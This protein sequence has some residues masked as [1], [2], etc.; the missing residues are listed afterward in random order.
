MDNKNYLFLVGAP[1]CG[2]SSLAHWLGTQQGV[3]LSRQKETMFFTDFAEQH[4]AGPGAENFASTIVA[5]DAEFREQFSDDF[6]AGLRVEASTDH[7]WCPGAA[8]RIAAFAARDDVG[9]VSVV[10]I[11]RDPVARIV[12]EYEHTL[13]LGWQTA[14]LMDSLKSEADRREKG[15]HPLFAHILRS[16]Y[17]QQITQYR[18]CFSDNLLVL[19]FHTL[20]DP[21]TLQSLAD[22]A[23]IA[24]DTSDTP[25]K[26]N[27]RDVPGRP[28]LARILRTRHLTSL[29][30]SLV[31]KRYRKFVRGKLEGG[32]MGR[33]Q[34]SQSELAFIR[35]ALAADIEACVRD[36]GI[37]TDNWSV[38]STG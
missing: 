3:A 17:H 1:K 20:A 5:K 22:F 29:G 26:K 25:G 32:R 10:A 8:E 37:A 28:K 31:P 24:C 7:L 23:E 13:R 34:P 4:W 15:W 36:P 14:G 19:D 12:S 9:N 33:Y 6:T 27:A 21:A 30:R 18:R 16:R 2:T 11:L 38:D 35:G